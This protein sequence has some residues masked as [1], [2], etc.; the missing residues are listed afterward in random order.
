M[1]TAFDLLTRLIVGGSLLIAGLTKLWS[2]VSWRQLWLAAYRLLP[3]PLVRPV[4]RGLP[5]AE[6][7]CGLAVA[8]GVLGAASALAAACL[9]AALAS[10]VAV[11]LAR[12]LEISCHCLTMVGEVISWR[13]VARNLVLAAAALAVAWHGGADLLGATGAGWPGQLG[14]LAAGVLAL[15]AAALVLRTVRRRQA[16]TD[17]AA[18]PPVA[19]GQGG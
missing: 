7:G 17:I 13:G 16:L 12:Q 6:I 18:R 5:A 19:A 9:L 15:H 1:W 2:T 11:A 3:R 8:A 10:A 14:A 4:A